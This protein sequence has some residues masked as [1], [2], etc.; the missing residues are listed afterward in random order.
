[1]PVCRK[2]RR[3]TQ[4]RADEVAGQFLCEV[5]FDT[6]TNHM[7]AVWNGVDI[8]VCE[9]CLAPP[10]DHACWQALAEAHHGVELRRDEHGQGYLVRLSNGVTIHFRWGEPLQSRRMR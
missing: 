5:C 2:A 7:T 3:Q 4:Q 6:L 8:A 9:D 10:S 1:M